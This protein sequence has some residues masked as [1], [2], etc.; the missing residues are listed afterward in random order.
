MSGDGGMPARGEVDAGAH[1]QRQFQN[2]GTARARLATIVAEIRTKFALVFAIANCY[3]EGLTGR[4]SR[5][6]RICFSPS[7]RR[8]SSPRISGTK[9]VERY[10]AGSNL[11]AWSQIQRRCSGHSL[12]KTKCAI[13]FSMQDTNSPGHRWHSRRGGSDFLCG[14]RGP[15]ASVIANYCAQS[16]GGGRLNSRL[17]GQ[18]KER[19]KLQVLPGRM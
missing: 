2:M 5:R 19:L 11:A 16:E 6:R 18:Q 12:R 15:G 3:V 8:R 1:Q 7:Y 9:W 17:V 13:P 4:K 10:L 14:S